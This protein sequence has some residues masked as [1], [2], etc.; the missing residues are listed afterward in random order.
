MNTEHGNGMGLSLVTVSHVADFYR[1]YP[2]ETLNFYTRIDVHETI[3]GFSLRVGIPPDLSL[4]RYQALHDHQAPLPTLETGSGSPSSVVRRPSQGLVWEMTD[5][6]AAGASYE[7]Q[8]VVTVPLIQEDRY[9]TSRVDI[10][11]E[12]TDG[13]RIWFETSAEVLLSA[14]SRYL[15]YL[16]AVYEQDEL[17]ARF[18]MLFESFWAPLDSQIDNIPFYLDP[19]MTPPDF[20]PWLASWLNLTLDAR[21]PEEK[22]R[23]LLQ[24]AISLYR[25]RGTKIG[26]QDYLEI[27]TGERP[28]IVEH[29]ANNL[30]LGPEARLG[31]GIAMGTE[32]VPHTFSVFFQ[33]P[34]AASPVTEDRERAERMRQRMIEQIIEAEKPAHTAYTLQI[35]IRQGEQS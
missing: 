35:E 29:R 6:L 28:Q 18:L 3:A 9:V 1:R 24:A 2:G 15:K 31:P 27:Y 7:Y 25:K 30:R 13:E 26:L 4:E 22:Q 8:T 16:P 33:L 10:A 14:R 20:L 23:Q 5:E 19:K 17:M 12:R 34:P 11:V 21:W 32:N